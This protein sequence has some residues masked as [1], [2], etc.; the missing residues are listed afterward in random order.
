MP[1]KLTIPIRLDPEAKPR[2]RRYKKV[3]P[4]G[5]AGH[6]Y[7]PTRPLKE[8][9]ALLATDQMRRKGYKIIEGDVILSANIFFKGKVPGDVD[10]L[11]N[12]LFD[13]LK[14]VVMRDDRLIK[15]LER[16]YALSNSGQD[17][18]VLEIRGVVDLWGEVK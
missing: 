15:G 7:S 14:G 6:F 1:I 8:E 18:I 4:D 2:F 3:Q 17:V 11:L 16:V 12:T 10:H 9:I 13:G 5:R